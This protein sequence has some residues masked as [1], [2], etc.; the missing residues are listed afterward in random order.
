[1]FHWDTHLSLA[2][3][4]CLDLNL[5][6]NSTGRPRPDLDHIQA[7]IERMRVQV[8][9]QRKEILQIQR[10]RISSATAEVVFGSMLGGAHC[11][12]VARA[13]IDDDV[14]ISD[15]PAGRGNPCVGGLRT[16]PNY[17]WPT[18]GLVFYAF[19]LL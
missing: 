13:A 2:A 17:C 19:D 15:I 14:R 7:E 5:A 10:A 9:R 11:L 8:G 18:D 4:V 1:M 6:L 3:S 16:R 12:I